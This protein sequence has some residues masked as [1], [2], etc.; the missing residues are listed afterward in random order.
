MVNHKIEIAPGIVGWLVGKDTVDRCPDHVVL[1]VA[2]NPAAMAALKAG[3]PV[4][5]VEDVMDGEVRH[6]C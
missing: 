5:Y 2:N 1:A 4:C 6:E 3:F